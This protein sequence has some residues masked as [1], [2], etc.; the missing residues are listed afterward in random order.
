MDGINIII[1]LIE[2]MIFN[3]IQLYNKFFNLKIKGNNK[4]VYINLKKNIIIDIIFFS[5]KLTI[6][7]IICYN[8][9][10]LKNKVLFINSNCMLNNIIKLSY[11]MTQSYYTNNISLYKL[12]SNIRLFKQQIL[13]LKWLFYLINFINKKKIKLP[14]KNTIKLYKIFLKLKYKYWNLININNIY[15]KYI[16]VILND[17]NSY[18][19]NKYNIFKNKCIYYICLHKYMIVNNNFNLLIC[20]NAVCVKILLEIIITALIQGNL[21]EKIK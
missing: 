5:K 15:F 12:F 16:F 3:K 17:T 2:Y 6:L 18:L 4:V 10:I 13:L 7:Y 19:I 21:V 1:N 20:N 9:S 11:I 8:T 14:F